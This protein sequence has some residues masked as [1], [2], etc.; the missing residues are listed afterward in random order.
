V[1]RELFQ[2]P[3]RRCPIAR[4]YTFERLGDRRFHSTAP[5]SVHMCTTR[6]ELKDCA[7]AITWII[8]ASQQS[9]RHQTLQHARQRAW[10]QVKDGRQIS[11]GDPREE[12]DD[13]QRQ[14]LWPGHTDLAN[15]PLRRLLEAVHNGPQQ[16]HE[17]KDVRQIVSSSGICSR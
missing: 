6:R 11:G 7:P 4:I 5:G 15:H 12:P 17:V 9:L 1:T 2:H 10:V 3:P 14:S 13:A 16:L 8:N